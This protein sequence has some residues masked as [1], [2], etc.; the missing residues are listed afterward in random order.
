MIENDPEM[1]DFVTTESVIQAD[2][3]R[4]QQE[5][6]YLDAVEDLKISLGKA[7]QTLTVVDMLQEQVKAEHG[8]Y[9]VVTQI[10]AA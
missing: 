8:K 9:T 10:I 6:A 2:K 1:R 4:K 5:T 7:K 3:S